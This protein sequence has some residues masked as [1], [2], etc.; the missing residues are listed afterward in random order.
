M[1]TIGERSTY[2]ASPSDIERN[3]IWKRAFAAYELRQW[4]LASEFFSAYLARYPHDPAA[5]L[6]QDRCRSS[7]VAR[8]PDALPLQLEFAE[9]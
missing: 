2:P 6:I 3:R 1:G 9:K 8:G 5:I 7:V 4:A